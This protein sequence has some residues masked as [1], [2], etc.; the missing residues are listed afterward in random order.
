MAA[1]YIAGTYFGHVEAGRSDRRCAE[2]LGLQTGVEIWFSNYTLLKLRQRHG[3]INFSHYGHLPSILL[4]GFLA[5][6]RKPNFLDFWWIDDRG[7]QPGAFFVVIK[8]TKS[9]EG[10][11]GTF[12][13]ISL[14]E[15]R[16]LYRRAKA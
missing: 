13:R 15:A 9:G 1:N 7:A 2:L 11:I 8:A 5:R 10:F 14:K 3:E 4:H 6:G 16:R 12:H